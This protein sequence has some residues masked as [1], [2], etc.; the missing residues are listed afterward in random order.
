MR[1]LEVVLTPP[2]RAR[3]QRILGVADLDRVSLSGEGWHRYAVLA[4]ECV[5]LLPRS[6]RWVP[7]LEREAAA[8]PL[9]ERHGIPAPR[10]LERIDDEELWPYPVTMISRYDAAPWSRWQDAA[11]RRGWQ[12]MLADLAE[13]IAGYQQIDPAAVPAPLR[14]PPPPSPDPLERTLLHVEDYLA[15]GRLERI[16][17]DLAAAAGIDQRRVATWMKIIEPCLQ[18]DP[19]LS[20]RDINEGQIMIGSDRSV[21]GLIDWESSGVQ[22]PF[23]DLDF[24]GWGPGIWGWEREHHLLRKGFW[25][26]YAAARGTGLPDFEAVELFMIIIGAPPPEGHTTAWTPQRRDRTLA[27]LRDADDRI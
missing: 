20:H 24:G 21:C 14:T 5:L 19:A 2:Q 18:L 10:L 23:S 9:L 27:N 17:R 1:A 22:H 3:L 13:L 11:D 16:G 25:R 12:R 26:R 7:G 15:T 8:L 4:P 6:H